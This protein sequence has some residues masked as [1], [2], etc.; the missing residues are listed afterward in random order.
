MNRKGQRRSQL[1]SPNQGDA[2][3]DWRSATA[4]FIARL[5]RRRR[6]QQ[7]QRRDRAARI[8]PDA[9]FIEE[10]ESRV[11]L[12]VV[13][14][15]NFAPMVAYTT[16]SA[17]LSVTTAD[18]NNDSQI[19]L[20]LTNENTNQVGV[21]FN[22]GGGSFA[23]A[24]YYAVGGEPTAVTSGDFNGDLSPDLAVVNTASGT[25]SILLNNGN[26]TFAPA[27][28]YNVGLHPVAI[29]AADFAG[30]GR[31]DLAVANYGSNTISVLMNNGNGTFAPAV[32]YAA[33]TTPISLVAADLNGDIAPRPGRRGFQHQSPQRADEQRQRNLR[34][35]RLLRRR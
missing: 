23:P 35:R 25:V 8:A 15:V 27:V 13:T 17:A 33:G 31:I 12:S 22:T 19:D 29:V 26:G 18:F 4:K 7:P 30:N 5:G 14:N 16:P 34:A 21:L 20:A 1:A 28:S 32:N 9:R 10:L 2:I 6:N 24:V 11:L 3:N